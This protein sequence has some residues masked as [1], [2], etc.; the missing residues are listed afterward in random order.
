MAVAVTAYLMPVG[1]LPAAAVGEAV[2]VLVGATVGAVVGVFVGAAVGVLVG[3]TVGAVVG[4]FV[5]AAVGVSVGATVGAVVGIAVESVG[6]AV[7]VTVGTEA[8]GVGCEL[9]AF[10]TACVVKSSNRAPVG[11]LVAPTLVGDAVGESV[12]PYEG[13]L[14]LVTQPEQ[15][16]ALAAINAV[17]HSDRAEGHTLQEAGEQSRVTVGDAVGMAVGAAVGIEVGTRLM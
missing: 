2:G 6:A 12:M 17:Q 5:G 9:G 14:L 15:R 4:I 16:L 8:P 11:A 7:G 3:A 13:Q 1:I 10:T